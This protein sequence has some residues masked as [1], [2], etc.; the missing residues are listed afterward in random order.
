VATASSAYDPAVCGSGAV[1]ANDGDRTGRAR[2]TNRVWN[3]AAPANTFPDWLEIDFNGSKTITEIDVITTQDHLEWPVEPTES[4][5]F[6][7]YGL[8]AYEVQYWNNSTWVTIPGGSVS[9]N[10]KVWLKFTFAAI[11]TS[12]IRV[13]ATASADGYSRIVELEAWTGPSPAPRY[14]LALGATATAST[15]YPGW[16]ASAVVNGPSGLGG[17]TYL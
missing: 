3:D 14:D 2:C 13:W 6:S 9:G 16:G 17:T 7:Q 15:S 4:M 11:T 12:K 10:N 1:S 5:T 8:T